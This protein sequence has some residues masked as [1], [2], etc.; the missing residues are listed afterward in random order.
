MNARQQLKRWRRANRL[1]QT[2]AGEKAGI[3][4]GVWSLL[5]QGARR[6]TLD[7]AFRIA[8]VT[9]NSPPAL[10]WA[11]VPR[12]LR[13]VSPSAPVDPNAPTEPPPPAESGDV[14]QPDEEGSTAA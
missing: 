4:Q 6:P 3:P 2:E 11:K 8:A 13:A 1:S 9:G 12:K 5:E 14:S 10:A 7:Q